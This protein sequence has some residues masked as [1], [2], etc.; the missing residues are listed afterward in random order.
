[1]VFDDYGHHPIEIAAVLKAAKQGAE[2]RVIAV[3]EPHRYSRVKALFEDF[4]SC[5]NDA[6]GVIVAPLYSAGET[7]LEG[8]SHHSLARAMHGAG[9]DDVFVA[10]NPDDIVL[11]ISRTANDGDIVI[12]F[13]AGHSTEWAHAVPH[14][15]ARLS[16]GVQRSA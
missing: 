2:G 9:K 10:E 4:C 16:A 5:L 11:L 8:I 12:F 1:T 14:Q 13:G 15:L 6:D 3:V 7:P